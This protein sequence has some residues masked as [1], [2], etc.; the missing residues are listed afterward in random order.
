[1]KIENYLSTDSFKSRKQLANE[2]GL[3]DRALRNKISKLKK[4]KKQ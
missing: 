1:M 3:T 2:T 4:K